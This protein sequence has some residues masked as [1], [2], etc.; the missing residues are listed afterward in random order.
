MVTIVPGLLLVT[1]SVST[2]RSFLVLKV[3]LEAITI[4]V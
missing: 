4:G 2:E 1:V 3:A